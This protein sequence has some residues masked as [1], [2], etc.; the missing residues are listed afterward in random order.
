[1]RFLSRCA[2]LLAVQ[3]APWQALATPCPDAAPSALTLRVAIDRAMCVDPRLAQARAEVARQQAVADEAAAARA[4]QVQLQAGP[5]ASAQQGTGRDTAS[6]AGAAT[7]TVSRTLSD[8]GLTQARIAQQERELAATRAE[9]EAER[10]NRLRD[11]VNAWTDAREAQATASAAQAALAAAR[12]SAA[13]VRA[14]VVVGTAT[15]VDALTTASA[16]A[17]AERDLLNAQT[18]VRTR[19]GV[20][21]ERLGWSADTAVA[22]QGD[23][24]AVLLPLAQAVEQSQPSSPLEAHPQLLAQTERARARNDALAAARADEGATWRVSGGTGPSITRANTATVSRYDT[25][26]RWGSEVAITWSKPLSDG[27]AKRSRTAQAQSAVDGALAQQA[28]TER[29]LRENL[30]QQWNAWRN[31]GADLRAAQAAFD[32]AQAAAAALR[33]RYEAGAGTLADVLSAQ[34]DL[35]L[36]SRQ[37]AAAEQSVLRSTAAAAHALGRLQLDL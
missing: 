16:Q 5:S 14:R 12:S 37:V 27:G 2:V 17:Q 9:M 15:Q 21:A 22:L 18:A 1:M 4:W 25:A 13:A 31:A 11:F 3:S 20:L 6:L 34:S 19:Q 10:Q 7:V 24:A 8:G 35:S 30:W 26:R 28:A 33:G 32:A 23:D 29:S 36:R